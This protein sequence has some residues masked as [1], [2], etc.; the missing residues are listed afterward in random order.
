MCVRERVRVFVCVS[1]N[2]RTNNHKNT[3]ET[4]PKV[5]LFIYVF[6]TDSSRPTCRKFDICSFTPKKKKF[7]V[8]VFSSAT[9]V[10]HMIHRC[11]GSD[12]RSRSL[13]LFHFLFNHFSFFLFP[14]FFPQFFFPCFFPFSLKTNKICT[15]IPP[16]FV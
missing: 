7:S 3:A 2:L 9:L 11:T 4:N 14:Q 1:G 8:N 15:P 10:K 16:S 13:F 6:N 12:S 5:Y